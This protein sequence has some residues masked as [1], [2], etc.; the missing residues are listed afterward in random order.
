MPEKK[1]VII[2]NY[3]Y[4]YG[5]DKMIHTNSTAKREQIFAYWVVGI[6]MEHSLAGGPLFWYGNYVVNSVMKQ[7]E[8]GLVH[9]RRKPT[10]LLLVL[11]LTLTLWYTLWY[12]F[13]RIPLT[14]IKVQNTLK[15]TWKEL[16]YFLENLWTLFW[17][18]DPLVKRSAH[19]WSFGG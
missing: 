6:I 11:S 12:S 18:G 3:W 16:F 13:F 5:V 14:L 9:Q 4:F 17:T 10:K 2:A 7:N 8:K 15:P 19:S 1:P